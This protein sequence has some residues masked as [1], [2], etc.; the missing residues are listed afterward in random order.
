MQSSKLLLLLSALVFAISTFIVTYENQKTKIT[1]T[2]KNARLIPN[3]TKENDD[4]LRKQPSQME[5][6][7]SEIDQL[8]E[9]TWKSSRVKKGDS[10]SKIFKRLKVPQEELIKLTR[11]NKNIGSIKPGQIIKVGF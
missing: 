8:V 11:A 10:L 9:E 3:A 6:Q 4:H 2:I 7:L 1:Q 5:L